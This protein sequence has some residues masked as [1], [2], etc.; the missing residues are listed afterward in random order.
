[1]PVAIGFLIGGIAS[2]IGYSL[3]NHIPLAWQAGVMA[4]AAVAILTMLA[5]TMI[6]EAFKGSRNWTG[7]IMCVGFL[8]APKEFE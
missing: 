6:P 8:V 7:F 5:D 1:M 3:C 4:C 2:L